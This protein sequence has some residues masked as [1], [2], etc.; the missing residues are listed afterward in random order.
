MLQEIDRFS[1]DKHM[2]RATL[3][4]NLIEQGLQEEKKRNVLE[5]YKQ[6]KYSLQRAASLLGLDILE[7][8]GLAER[9]GIYLDYD[10]R[11]LRADLKGLAR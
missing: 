1:A 6:R 5:G 8:L 2:D 11:E 4:R 3:L 10:R 9:E 7:M